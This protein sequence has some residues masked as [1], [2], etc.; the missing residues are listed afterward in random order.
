MKRFLL[1]LAL[2][3]PSPAFAVVCRH[4]GGWNSAMGLMPCPECEAEGYKIPP[5]YKW[6]NAHLA[7]SGTAVGRQR[8]AG[9]QGWP[10]SP[11][12]DQYGWPIRSQ[13][14]PIYGS[15]PSTPNGG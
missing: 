12:F 2:L 4:S 8:E 5:G 15:S 1:A 13:P 11:P 14:R 9:Q 10:D 6:Y 3:T 7:P